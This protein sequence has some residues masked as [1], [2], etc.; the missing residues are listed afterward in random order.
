MKLKL[1]GNFCDLLSAFRACSVRYLIIGGWAVSIH[2]QPRAT[3]DMDILVSPDRSNI[4]AVYEALMRFGAPLKNMSKSEFLEPGT[5]FRIGAPPCQVDIFPGIPGVQFE[6]CWPNR[7]EV[8]LDAEGA[9]S[10]NFI[11]AKDLIAAKTASGREQDLAD[12]QAI[13]R[14]Q[15]QKPKA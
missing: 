2:A 11:S 15:Q 12:A 10:A 14:A 13:R 9:L 5:F 4:E 8:L 3:Q 6:E 1:D 7:V